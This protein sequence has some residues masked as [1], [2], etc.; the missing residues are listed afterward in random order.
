MGSPLAALPLTTARL[1]LTFRVQH[2]ARLNYVKRSRSSLKGQVWTE[3][4]M[5]R[6]IKDCFAYP[7]FGVLMCATTSL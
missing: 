5:S 3:R 6:N 1:T 4:K 2:R 7:V